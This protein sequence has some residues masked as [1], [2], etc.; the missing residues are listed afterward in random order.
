MKRYIIVFLLLC[1]LLLTGFTSTARYS[2]VEMEVYED[3]DTGYNTWSTLRLDDHYISLPCSARL[4]TDLGYKAPTDIPN[5]APNY[6]MSMISFINGAGEELNLSVINLDKTPKSASECYVYDVTWYADYTGDIDVMG[7][8][9]GNTSSEVA[10]V[11]G[12][13]VHKGDGLNGAIM[14]FYESK[15]AERELSVTYDTNDIAIEFSVSTEEPEIAG[16][17]SQWDKTPSTDNL[18][19]EDEN[20]SS[21]QTFYDEDNETIIS[22]V[23]TPN[24]EAFLLGLT[25]VC[26][27]FIACIIIIVVLFAI[28][29]HN[30]ASYEVDAFARAEE[31]KEARRI[32]NTDIDD[33]ADEINEDK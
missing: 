31:L 30:L 21:R 27:I 12:E 20:R 3:Y 32:L 9:Q 28:R 16:Y 11:I 5:V 13:S 25:V 1:S 8:A 10:S 22:V 18:L 29:K 24:S 26:V 6:K 17:Q 14:R 15:H 4:F 7:A 23:S 33:L 2:G 19:S